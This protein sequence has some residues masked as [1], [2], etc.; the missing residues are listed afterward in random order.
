[1]IPLNAVLPA[2]AGF[3]TFFG[4]L[5]IVVS[6]SGVRRRDVMDT[7]LADATR[8]AP[9]VEELEMQAPFAERF[10]KPIAMNISQLVARITPTRV[11]ENTRQRLVHAGYSGRMQVSDFL[12]IKGLCTMVGAGLAL[13]LSLAT[14]LDLVVLLLLIAVFGGLGYYFPD[15]WL[16]GEISKRKT[17]LTNE[18]PD[19]LDLLTISVEAGLGFDQAIARII[20]K[21]S[22]TA[23]SQEF[24]RVLAQ[25]QFGFS[26]RD[27]LRALSERTGVDDLNTFVAAIIQ[28]E[29]LGASVGRVLRI[30]SDEMR[31]RRRQRAETLA[32]QAPIKMLFPMAFLIF[33]PIFIV[34]LGPAIPKIIYAFAP[35]IHL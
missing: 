28:A 31:T 15:L 33:P 25:M 9:T 21:S 30:Q 19:F 6:L 17:L 23:L 8:N 14:G 26:R 22:D 24:G 27:A 32:H 5:L 35:G 13:M 3:L 16:R 11:M 10:V 29:Q 4:V 34:V 2:L 7:R 1:M 20:S 12:G 18:L